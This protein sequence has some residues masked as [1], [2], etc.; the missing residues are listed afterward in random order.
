MDNAKMIGK[1][2]GIFSSPEGGA[3]VATLPKLLDLGVINSKDRIV[4]FITGSGLKY[5]DLF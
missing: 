4:L 3:T 2:E 1:H 5:V